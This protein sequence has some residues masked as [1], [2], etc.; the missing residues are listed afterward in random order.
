MKPPPMTAAKQRMAAHTEN[1]L[2]MEMR[3]AYNEGQMPFPFNEQIRGISETAEY[4]QKFGSQKIKKFADNPKTMK[5]CFEAL[6]FLE[7]GQVL[8]KDRNEKPSLWIVRNQNKLRE[9]YKNT[10]LCNNIWKPLQQISNV[11]QKEQRQ[12]DNFRSV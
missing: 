4:Y 5:K 1:P 11:D 2:L 6:E 12:I 7:I 3:T 8:H 9:Q 10:D